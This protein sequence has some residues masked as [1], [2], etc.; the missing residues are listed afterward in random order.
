MALTKDHY[1]AIE[2]EK[3]ESTLAWLLPKGFV[4]WTSGPVLTRANL[5]REPG[6][7]T[8]LRNG[9]FTL[10]LNYF[11]RK[12]FWSS[13]VQPL[14]PGQKFPYSTVDTFRNSDKAPA[15]G[16]L[17]LKLGGVSGDVEKGWK[18][19]GVTLIK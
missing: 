7:V 15:I 16:L 1:Y 11:L 19:V 5:D 14:P 18:V 9:T 2:K 4:S 13:Y 17:D 8:I 10:N 12:L 6:V 3:V